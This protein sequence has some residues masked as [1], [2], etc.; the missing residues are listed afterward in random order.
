MI[1]VIVISMRCT[2]AV[3]WAA[4]IASILQENLIDKSKIFAFGKRDVTEVTAE[5]WTQSSSRG[6]SRE[7]SRKTMSH[8][9]LPDWAV[10]EPAVVYFHLA[11]P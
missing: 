1:R 5:N 11:A 9:N 8:H 3:D 2:D 7:S 6:T 10:R 4:G